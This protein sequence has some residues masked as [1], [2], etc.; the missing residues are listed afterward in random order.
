M[1]T[2]SERCAAAVQEL[3]NHGGFLALADFIAALDPAFEP[4]PAPPPDQPEGEPA[5]SPPPTVAGDPALSDD[6][7][8]EPAA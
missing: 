8:G 7:P 4:E 2:L 5:P 3:R 6:A 1:T